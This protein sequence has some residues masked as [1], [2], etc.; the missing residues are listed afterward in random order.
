MSSSRSNG[1]VVHKEMEDAVILLARVVGEDT[2]VSYGLFEAPI[3]GEFGNN[4]L[5][6][7]VPCL[8]CPIEGFHKAMTH[9]RRY[10]DPWGVDVYGHVH[11]GL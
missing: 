11:I 10:L 3:V 9:A 7:I 5:M 1:E 2:W 6:P 8:L 4:G